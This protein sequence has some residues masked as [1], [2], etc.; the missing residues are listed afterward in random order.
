MSFLD[1]DEKILRIA[2]LPMRSARYRKKCKASFGYRPV[3]LQPALSD[4]NR[5]GVC[6]SWPVQKSSSNFCTLLLQFSFQLRADLGSL[7]SL[8]HV[9]ILVFHG[10]IVNIII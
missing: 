2:P 3:P 6:K 4:C 9:R 8:G 7:H 5:S 10:N 1:R